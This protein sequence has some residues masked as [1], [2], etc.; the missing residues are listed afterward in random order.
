MAQKIKINNREY[1]IDSLSDT[2]KNFCEQLRVLDMAINEKNNLS[3]VLLKAKK[4]YIMDLKSEML[5]QKA[6]YDFSE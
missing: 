1:D 4:A 3:A 2:A 5:S 6:G